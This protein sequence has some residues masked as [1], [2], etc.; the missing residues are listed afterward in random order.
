MVR[1]TE[2]KRELILKIM[3]KWNTNSSVGTLVYDLIP[4]NP[5]GN[6]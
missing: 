1:T 4:N 3:L 2:L 6:S 5:R